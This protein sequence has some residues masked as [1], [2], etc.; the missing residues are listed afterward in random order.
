MSFS[1]KLILTG[2]SLFAAFIWFIVYEM[3]NRPPAPEAQRQENFTQK[4]VLSNPKVIAEQN[5]DT[6]TTKN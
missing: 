3:A 1:D 5:P 6:S 2:S 4:T